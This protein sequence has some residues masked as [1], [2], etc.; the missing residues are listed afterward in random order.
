[1]KRVNV[2][3]DKTDANCSKVRRHLIYSDVYTDSENDDINLPEPIAMSKLEA[4]D[5]H[6][7]MFVLVDLLTEKKNT[8]TRKS[9]YIAICQS[10]VDNE[11]DVQVMFLKAVGN[12]KKKKLS[13]MKMM[14]HLYS[15]TKLFVNWQYPTRKLEETDLFM[16]LTQQL[17][18]LLH[19]GNMCMNALNIRKWFKDSNISNQ[20]AYFC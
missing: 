14:L 20:L 3:R 17:L 2:F 1:M 6:S 7:G 18:V 4:S 13:Q 8:S 19:E 10:D 16:N 15:C 12:D 5:I 11:D 9:S